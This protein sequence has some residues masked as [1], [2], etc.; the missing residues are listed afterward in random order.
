MLD[1]V[2]IWG[3]PPANSKKIFEVEKDFTINL[4]HLFHISPTRVQVGIIQYGREVQIEYRLSDLY[5]NQQ[6]L[7]AVNRLVSRTPGNNLIAALRE[8]RLKLFNL[9]NDDNLKNHARSNVPK[10]LLLFNT[11]KSIIEINELETEINIMREAGI[12]IVTVTFDSSDEENIFQQSSD[13][14]SHFLVEN[15]SQLN[16]LLQ[17][18]FQQLLPGI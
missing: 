18:V 17:P 3:T 5:N 10:S 6:A 16:G 11:K 2:I 8:V 12:K 9:Q 1:V 7:S 13:Q 15:L 4:L 14:H